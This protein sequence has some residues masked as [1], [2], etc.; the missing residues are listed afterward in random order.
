M[1]EPWLVW[2]LIGIGCIGIEMLMPGFVIFFFGLGGLA[3]AL[4]CLVPFISDQVWLQILL[5]VVFS[6]FSLVYLRKRFTRIFGGTV[7]DPHKGNA[8][9]EG[10]GGLAEVIED[11]GSLK[12]GR[13]RFRGTSWKAKTGSGIFVKG[14]I[15]R[16]VSREDLTYIVDR[17]G[18]E[19]GKNG[20]N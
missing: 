11:I 12:E 4:C 20:G 16:I 8:D 17:A 1:Y 6:V 5:F 9:D 13:I 2:A 7:F 15:V 14:D 10:V 3:T 18:D 19:P